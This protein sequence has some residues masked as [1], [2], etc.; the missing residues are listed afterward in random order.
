[1]N[2]VTL[3]LSVSPFDTAGRISRASSGRRTALSHGQEEG[4]LLLSENNATGVKINNPQSETPWEKC[5]YF[6]VFAQSK[7]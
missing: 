2:W 7:G 1:M 4:S 5:M 6:K 3:S